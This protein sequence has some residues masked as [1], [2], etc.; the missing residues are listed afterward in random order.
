M[1]SHTGP[2][3]HWTQSSVS[4]WQE[5]HS[6]S[7]TPTQTGSHELLTRSARRLSAP[8]PPQW[9]LCQ[10]SEGKYVVPLRLSLQNSIYNTSTHT[11]PVAQSGHSFAGF[12]TLSLININ[13]LLPRWGKINYKWLG[14][15]G[16]SKFSLPVW[17]EII[18]RP[19]AETVKKHP[20]RVEIWH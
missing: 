20:Y 17:S 14:F 4:C 7:E 3:Q 8:P 1:E 2:W 12:L 10:S 9:A 18:A 16:K 5:H 6:T 13:P 19:R 11:H 15:C